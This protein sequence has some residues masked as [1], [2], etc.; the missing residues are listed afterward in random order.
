MVWLSVPALLLTVQVYSPPS[1][2][3]RLLIVRVLVLVV[4]VAEKSFIILLQ[5]YSKSGPP[6]DKQF[7]SN[8]SPL[9]YV[10]SPMMVT[11]YGAT[12]RYQKKYAL[13][14]NKKSSQGS[15]RTGLFK[16]KNITLKFSSK[17]LGSIVGKPK[18][19]KIEILK[20]SFNRNFLPR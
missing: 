15:L 2:V 7:N 6:S 5:L 12:K 4:V 11:L 17:K 3:V 20:F 13:M 19:V 8:S 18:N 14:T 10:L 16:P 9:S 1:T